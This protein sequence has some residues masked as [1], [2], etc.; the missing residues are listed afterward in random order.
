M[1]TTS[2]VIPTDVMLQTKLTE[3]AEQYGRNK[4]I[5]ESIDLIRADQAT[6]ADQIARTERA[7]VAYRGEDEEKAHVEVPPAAEG[8]AT[9]AT[10]LPGGEGNSLMDQIQRSQGGRSSKEASSSRDASSAVNEQLEAPE[11]PK[12]K[13]RGVRN[14][15]PGHVPVYV[16]RTG[17][18]FTAEDGA[19]RDLIQELIMKTLA[20]QQD[21][22]VP[23]ITRHPELLALG[24]YAHSPKRQIVQMAFYEL[25]DKGVLKKSLTKTRG[26][27]KS[28][29][30]T[31]VAA[32][33]SE[34][35][36]EED[37]TSLGAG[38]GLSE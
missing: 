10:E 5:L 16:K 2:E 8:G 9:A 13:R 11:P 32:R 21:V 34:T 7:L 24:D 26:T 29:V 36:Q 31:L 20:T 22:I 3:L 28:P 18:K 33:E 38:V 35:E 4:I 25:V 37:S 30:Y 19:E 27:H 15:E 12:K 23:E 14:T 6:I 1:T 17:K